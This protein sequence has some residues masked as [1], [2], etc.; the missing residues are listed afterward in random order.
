MH[1]SP[2]P[3]TLG[4]QYYRVLDLIGEKGAEVTSVGSR[5]ILLLLPLLTQI[6]AY[7]HVCTYLRPHLLQGPLFVRELYLCLL[8]P[9]FHVLNLKITII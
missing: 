1:P 5:P 4:G 6:I 8:A 9:H 3:L 7:H 2:R